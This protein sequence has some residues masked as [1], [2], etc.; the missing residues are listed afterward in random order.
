MEQINVNVTDFTLS[1]TSVIDNIS[2]RVLYIE[3]FK[4]VTVGAMLMSKNICVDNKHFTISGD[5]YKKW[6]ND[7]NYITNYVLDALNATRAPEPTPEPT[8]E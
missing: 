4:S 8:P 7:D 1:K 6:G 3:L 5:D 2:I